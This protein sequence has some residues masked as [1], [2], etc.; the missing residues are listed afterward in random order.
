VFQSYA[1]F[2]PA[3]DKLNAR[4]L[5]SPAGADHI[6]MQWDDIDGKQPLL[7]DPASWR[8]LF[9]HYDVQLTRPDLLVLKRRESS[10]YR[11][12]R[13][14]GS[15]VAGWQSEIAVPEAARNQFT[16]MS[17]EIDKSIYG[18]LLGV[19]L[20][21]SP[22][23]VNATYSSGIQYKWRVTRAN[24]VDGALI[25]YLPETVNKMLPYFGQTGDLPP[26]RVVSIRFETTGQAEFSSLIRIS[27]YALA[28]K[29]DE[30]AVSSD[31]TT[32]PAVKFSK[33]GVFRQPAQGSLFVL[34]ATGNRTSGLAAYK[35]ARFGGSDDI[36]VAGDWDGTSIVRIGVYRP[37]NGHWY[38]DMNNNGKWDPGTDLDILLGSPSAACVPTTAAGLAACPDIPI[39]GDW[40][41]TGVSKLGIFR[42]GHWSLDKK[43]PGDSGPHTAFTTYTYGSPGDLP[44]AANWNH[45]GTADQIGVYRRGTWYVDS[46]GDGFYE[47]ND[48][49]YTFG[50]P[51][52]F[53][54]TGNWSSGGKKIGVMNPSGHWYLDI[55]GDHIF[56]LP[57]DSI[58]NYGQAGDLP[59]VGGPWTIP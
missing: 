38:L 22:T 14:I 35:F 48:A 31:A 56:T 4:D 44:V 23:F 26:D 5:A 11:E 21:N 16:I 57:F 10:R 51:S 13:L 49:T 36:P 17:V 41:G 34:D 8:S 3:L 12:P 2:T 1:A 29:P 15:A 45:T 9:D 47:S 33:L 37:A 24:L 46:N 7:D 42:A 43:N 52:D 55:N 6:I 18:R 40:T 54:V 25:S 53:P 19:L 39:V 30:L 58:V 20:R 32:T 59:V 28:A 50:S 27:W